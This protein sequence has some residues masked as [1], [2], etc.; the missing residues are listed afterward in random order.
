MTTRIFHDLLTH[1]ARPLRIE[2][3]ARNQELH[4]RRIIAR[5]EPMLLVEVVRPL[6]FRHVDLD[7]ETGPLGHRDLSSHDPK[8]L[9]VQPLAV[10]PDPVRIDGGDAPWRGGRYMRHHRERNIEVIVRMR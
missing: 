8:W 4:R 3:P 9:S 7:A 5:A 6:D 1:H 2:T 10:L